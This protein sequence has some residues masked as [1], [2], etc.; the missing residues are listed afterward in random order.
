MKTDCDVL[1]VGGGLAGVSCALR[2][3]ET[4]R[5]VLIVERRPALGWEST[6]AGQLQ[7]AGI[8][9]PIARRIADELTRVGGLCDGVADG[10]VIE[11]ALDRMLWQAGASVL[12]YSYPVQL[13]YRDEYAYGVL[14]ASR[15][16]EQTVRAGVVVDATEEAVLWSQT[17]VQAGV[18]EPPRGLYSFFMNHA[19]DGLPLPLDLGDGVVVHPSLWEGE[20]RVEYI[21]DEASA[22]AARRALP[23]MIARARQVPQLAE[24]LVSHV[25]NEPF[26]LGPLARFEGAA[27]AHPQICNLFACG[28]WAVDIENTPAGRL[29]LGEQVGE[30]VAGCQGPDVFPEATLAGSVVER[31]E[32]T[33][34]VLVVG[35]GT[36]GSIAAIVAAREGV[37]TTL[38]ETGLS[39]GGIG[40]AGAIHS[41]YYGLNGGLQDEVD[42]RVKE[43]TPLFCGAWDVRGLK[44]HLVQGMVFSP[45]SRSLAFWASRGGNWFVV[46]NGERVRGEY[47]RPSPLKSNPGRSHLVFTGVKGGRTHRVRI[48]W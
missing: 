21:V 39:L 5:S 33:S 34:D 22:L 23:G 32:I 41:Y 18:L 47:D 13:L 35:G 11:I 31:P 26:P 29:A 37:R 25:A 30:A 16:G 14:L 42:A 43:L 48:R 46:K 40:T 20:V 7:Y 36:G 12:L 15:C 2:A 9:S 3:A 28:V 1:I 19:Q 8:H 17:G 45:D 10:P 24:A 6:W 44:A 27:I 4:G 38:I